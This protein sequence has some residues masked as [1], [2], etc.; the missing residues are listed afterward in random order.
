MSLSV[1]DSASLWLIPLA[2]G[3]KIMP[4]ARVLMPKQ[5]NMRYTKLLPTRP[6]TAALMLPSGRAF[7]AARPSARPTP[8]GKCGRRQISLTLAP[9][10]HVL[11]LSS[12]EDRLVDPFCSPQ[13]ADAW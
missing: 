3:M 7:A 11:V 10:C 4:A 9:R 1:A 12:T 13:L 5:L 2:Q 6:A 8:Q